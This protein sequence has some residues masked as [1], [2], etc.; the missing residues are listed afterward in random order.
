MA[1][2]ISADVKCPF[3]ADESR[4]CVT[5]EG[6]PEDTTHS[7]CFSSPAVKIAWM[8]KYCI[9]KYNECPYAKLLYQKYE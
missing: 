3:F 4:R 8:R 9:E 2:W 7:V 5:C 1:V 6:L